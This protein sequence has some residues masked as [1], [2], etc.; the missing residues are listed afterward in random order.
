MKIPYVLLDFSSDVTNMSSQWDMTLIKD[1]LDGKLWQAA[2]GYQFKQWSVDEFKLPNDGAVLVIPAR[3]NA[4]LVNRNRIQNYISELDWCVL[5]LVGDE[6]R[7]FDYQALNH[8]N[9]KVWLMQPKPDDKADFYLG[10][11][12]TP[13]LK[14]LLPELKPQYDLKPY[15]WSFMGQNNHVRRNIAAEQMTAIEPRE[16]WAAYLLMTDGFTQ[17]KER[18]D[19]CQILAGSKAVPAPSGIASPD[20]FRVFEALEA[21]AVPIADDISALWSDEGYWRKVF[22][23]EDVPFK[24][25]S[26]YANLEGYLA[27]IIRDYPQYQ[28]RVFAWWQGYKRKMAYTLSQH[29]HEVSGI[30]YPHDEVRHKITVIVLTSPIKSHPST[31][32]I[33]RTINDMQAV[34]PGCEILIGVDGVRAEQEDYRPRYEEYKKALLWKCS[35]EWSNV[36]PVIFEEHMH[37]AAMTR[38]LLTMVNTETIMFVEHDT[39]LAPDFEYDWD[40]F[41]K[42]IETG[43]AYTIRF[44]FEATIPE[45]HKPMMIGEVEDI[46]GVPLLRT[47]QWSQRP[48]LSSTVFYRDMMDRYFTDES[49]TMIE[50]KVHGFPAEA[51]IADGLLG[52]YNWRLWIY[53]PDG[54]IKR[55]YTSDG[56]GDDPKYEMRF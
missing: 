19:Y 38:K 21:G 16:D 20:S 52:W 8:S 50:D 27:D 43:S 30:D 3:Q 45:P 23:G 32:V 5:I 28:N 56:R 41:L 12:Y 37:Q 4:E 44:H 24:I 54:H 25:I 22:E 55:S 11:G 1:L 18:A 53:H 6:E 48:H 7:T 49:R 26:D 34:L 36:V 51:Y 40:K 33:E 15:D 2:E 35:N 39:A 14:K 29:V 17:G 42:A 10:S 13:H 46:C 9:M 47:S 31:E